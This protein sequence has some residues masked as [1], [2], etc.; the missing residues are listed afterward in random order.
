MD[1]NG[2]ILITSTTKGYINIK[3]VLSLHLNDLAILEYI[4]SV[5]KLGQIKIY[6]DSRSPICKLII[7]KTDL[8]EIFFP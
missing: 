7:N 5:L 8:Q 3:L 6:P 4:K 2:S 1:G